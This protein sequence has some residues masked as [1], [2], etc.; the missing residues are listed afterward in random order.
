M[1]KATGSKQG[2]PT[3]FLG[4]TRKN[5]EKFLAEMGDTFIFIDQAEMG[6][7]FDIIIFSGEDEE[8]LAKLM[9]PSI[10]PDT[11]IHDRRR[12]P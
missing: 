5:L 8:T 2:R 12:K 4:L 6:L 1:I 9:A 10:G 3:I 7:K 11:V